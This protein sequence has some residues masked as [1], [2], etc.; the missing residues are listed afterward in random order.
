M[1][2]GIFVQ[3]FFKLNPKISNDARYKED[4]KAFRGWIKNLDI[5]ILVLEIKL[6]DENVIPT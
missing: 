1:K 3:H 2:I 5:A 4:Q 6:E